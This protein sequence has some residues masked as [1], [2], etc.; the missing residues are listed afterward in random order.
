MF[1]RSIRFGLAAVALAVTAFSGAFQVFGD[2]LSA[3]IGMAKRAAGWLFDWPSLK[4]QAEAKAEQAERPLVRLVSA[5]AYK[6]RLIKR[7]R[8][9]VT[10]DWRMCPSV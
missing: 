5:V 4:V 10:P 2:V 7:Q 9:V 1:K 6:L 3:S 8:P